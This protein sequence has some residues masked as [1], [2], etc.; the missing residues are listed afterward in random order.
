MYASYC[1]FVSW[2]ASAVFCPLSLGSGTPYILSDDAD[3][4]L[5]SGLR[6]NEFE[7]QS[8]RPGSIKMF[9]MIAGLLIL[10]AACGTILRLM[11][12]VGVLLGAAVI[13]VAVTVV[14]GSVGAAL[15]NALIAAV[16]LQVGYAAGV[17]LRAAIRSRQSRTP[18]REA[19]KRPV[20]APLGEK[21]Q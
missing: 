18:A 12:F 2:R 7:G 5:A 13:A 9:W 6:A 17:V 21:R 15:L 20:S 16:V 19:P 11:I 14:Q 10:G 3:R 1:S 4:R 8:G